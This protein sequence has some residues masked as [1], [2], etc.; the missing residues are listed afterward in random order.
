MH[1]VCYM[2]HC[3]RSEQSCSKGFKARANKAKQILRTLE[4]RS[5]FF[6]WLNWPLFHN[7]ESWEVWILLA[8]VGLR[9]ESGTFGRDLMI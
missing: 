1:S 7:S 5:C 2:V 9:Q 8:V 4:A 6:F 3:E